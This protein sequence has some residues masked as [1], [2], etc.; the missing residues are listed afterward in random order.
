MNQARRKILVQNAQ[1]VIKMQQ[2]GKKLK[3]YLDL[4]IW[5]VLFALN[6]GAENVEK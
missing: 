2:T 1:D 4:E 6:L 5:M 3:N